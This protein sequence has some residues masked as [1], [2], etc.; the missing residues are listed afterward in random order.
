LSFLVG[1]VIKNPPPN[2]G[3][4][5][6]MGLILGWEDPWEWEMATHSIMLAWKIPW[7]DEPGR[8]PSMGSQRVVHN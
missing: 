3:D 7:T 4:V 5:R 6:D 2:E 1:A 8:L